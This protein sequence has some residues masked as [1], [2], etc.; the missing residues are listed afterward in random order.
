MPGKGTW[1][2]FGE[3]E[4]LFS[5]EAENAGSKPGSAPN[6]PCAT[7]DKLLSLSVPLFPCLYNGLKQQYLWDHCA[8]GRK[9]ESPSGHKAL[10]CEC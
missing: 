3:G 6:L 7:L 2:L 8:E 9:N 5:V 1:M 4:M 10:F